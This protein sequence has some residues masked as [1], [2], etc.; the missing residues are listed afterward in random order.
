[1]NKERINDFIECYSR[2]IGLSNEYK[3]ILKELIPKLI[4]KYSKVASEISVDTDAYDKYIIKPVNGKYSIE[5]FFLNRLMASVLEV[6]QSNDSK[7]QMKGGFWD[8][9]H[10]I[11]LNDSAINRQLDGMLPDDMENKSEVRNIA[12]KKVIMHE[13]EHAM[14]TQYKKDSPVD[15]LTKSNLEN[16]IKEISAIKGGKYT[17]QINSFQELMSRPQKYIGK[18]VIHN[19]LKNQSYSS[20]ISRNTNEIFN[21]TESLEMA[22]AKVQTRRYFS[23]GSYL[24]IRNNESSNYKTTNYGE[25]VK[26]L[27][28]EKTTF[29]GMYLDPDKMFQTFN[30][31][32]ND[33]FQE[34]FQNDKS[35]WENFMEQINVIKSKSFEDG[36]DDHLMLQEVLAKCFE[37]KIENTLEKDD[38]DK[39]KRQ[40]RCFKDNCIWSDDKKVRNNLKHFQILKS[41]KEKIETK[42]K[43]KDEQNVSQAEVQASNKEK[44]IHIMSSN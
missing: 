19:G 21:E 11:T 9:T 22:D 23:D 34:A 43:S 38:I 27:L 6:Q 44:F 17:K 7:D 26:I 15:L 32:Y 36:K 18:T 3:D 25:L 41:I 5:D 4:N 1:M 42:E 28:G 39:L 24:Q 37:R 12:R 16:V 40:F 29:M 31:R 10:K 33:I 30:N 20:E 13:F 14:Q 2:G 8:E 35:A